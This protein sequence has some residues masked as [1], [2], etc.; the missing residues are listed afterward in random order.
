MSSAFDNGIPN[1]Q[2]SDATRNAARKTIFNN[3]RREVRGTNVRKA[4]R[5]QP[6]RVCTTDGCVVSTPSYQSKMDVNFGWL[7]C[8]TSWCAYNMTNPANRST[9]GKYLE[10][11]T[12]TVT[13]PVVDTTAGAG[14]FATVSYG[15]QLTPNSSK[16][17]M[18]L[19]TTYYS[20]YKPADLHVDPDGK[21]FSG[22][23]MKTSSSTNQDVR[24]CRKNSSLW[25]NYIAPQTQYTQYADS[26]PYQVIAAQN[27]S[28]VPTNV[29]YGTRYSILKTNGTK[30][31][32]NPVTPCLC[33]DAT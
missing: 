26:N 20:I 4:M 28:R 9:A 11:N 3:L 1:L 8:E 22:Q 10:L 13:Q 6:V 5:Y 12:S 14:T 2:A 29:T 31:E 23:Q 25:T 27:T 16:L 17:V 7:L 24:Y 33:D 32:N 21:L 18:D 30:N 19:G 15:Y